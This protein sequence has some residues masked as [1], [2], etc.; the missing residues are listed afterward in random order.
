M[1]WR[2]MR[3]R[4]DYCSDSFER[5]GLSYWGSFHL[6]GTPTREF[7]ADNEGK[8][9]EIFLLGVLWVCNI[10]KQLTLQ[11]QQKLV[12]KSVSHE[13]QAWLVDV[14]SYGSCCIWEGAPQASCILWL[15][16]EEKL[17]PKVFPKIPSHKNVFLEREEDFYVFSLTA[18]NVFEII[19]MC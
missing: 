13:A 2:H 12:K 8:R 18:Q 5:H 6:L 17:N 3:E 14:L 15:K 16:R 7:Y 19:G 10:K 9:R 1:W 4:T 11:V